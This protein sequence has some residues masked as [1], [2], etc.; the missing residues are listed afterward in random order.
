M[1]EW[2]GCLDAVTPDDI[3][4]NYPSI[5]CPAWYVQS[6][7]KVLDGYEVSDLPHWYN[8]DAASMFGMVGVRLPT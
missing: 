7:R 4:P 2:S 8:R 6:Y 3:G 1:L 5:F